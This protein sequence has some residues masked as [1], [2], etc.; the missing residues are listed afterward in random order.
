MEIELL[1]YKD[2][3]TISIFWSNANS[4]HVFIKVALEVALEVL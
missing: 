4:L 3:V 2:V 1:N